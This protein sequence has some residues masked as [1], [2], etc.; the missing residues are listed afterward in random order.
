MTDP[1]PE[2]ADSDRSLDV[3]VLVDEIADEF[4]LAVR[5]GTIL[6]IDA[7][8]ASHPTVIANPAIEVPL[9]RMLETLRLL[10]G[11]GAESF[12]AGKPA[13][14]LPEQEFGLPEIAD[15]RLLRVAGRGGMGVVYEAMQLSLSRKVALKVLPEH[16]FGNPNALARFQLEARSAAGLHHT[17]IVPVFEV[18]NDGRHCFYAMQFIEGHSLDEVIR[19]LREIRD[20]DESKS[21][22]GLP[23]EVEPTV[24]EVA[25]TFGDEI[26]KPQLLASST[27][28]SS[29]TTSVSQQSKPFFRN[30]AR[31]GRQIAD[32]LG[33]A[34]QRG[35]VHRDIKPSNI[36]LDPQGVAWITD[37]GLAKTDDVDLTRDGDVVGTLRYMSPERFAGTCD[38]CSDVYSLGVT[39]YEM[40]ALQSPFAG[41][42]RLSLISAIQ[43]VGPPSLRSLNTR[44][45]R[46]LQ[47]IVEKAMEKEPRR[48]YRTAAAMADDLER[49]LDGRPIWARRVGA[50]ECLWLWSKNNASLASSIA[51]IALL[52]VCGAIGSTFAAFH[53]RAQERTQAQLAMEKMAESQRANRQRDAANQNAYF[54]DIR[55]SYQDWE[56]GDVR[57]MQTALRRYVPKQDEQPKQDEKDIRGWEWNYLLSLS[58]QSETTLTNFEGFFHQLQW[59][60]DGMRLFGCGSQGGLFIW[61][62]QGELIK[63]IE[64]PGIQRFALSHDGSEVATVRG[65]SDL[66]FWNTQT[67]ELVQTIRVAGGDA[68]LS[69]VGWGKFPNLITVGSA[70]TAKNP[71]GE[72]F[73]LE[74]FTQFILQHQDGNQTRANWMLARPQGDA[75]AVGGPKMGVTIVFAGCEMQT[76][77]D[78]QVLNSFNDL[79]CL[80]WHP[81][82]RRI[83]VGNVSIG[84]SLFE[85]NRGERLPKLLFRTSDLT[86]ADAVTFSPD[87]K[88]MIVGNRAGR[89]DVY[90]LESREKIVSYRGHMKNVLAVAAHPSGKLIAS[91]GDDGAIRFWT[92]NNDLV[93]MPANASLDQEGVSPDG[94]WRWVQQDH[95]VSVLDAQTGQ[96]MASLS[97]K[98]GPVQAK[99][100]P[101]VDRAVFFEEKQYGDDGQIVFDTRSWDLIGQAGAFS[102]T[103]PQIDSR[104]DFVVSS[105]KGVVS[106]FSGRTGDIKSFLVD[107]NVV[108]AK[109]GSIESAH[110]GVSLSPTGDRFVT[111]SGGEFKLWDTQ[112]C[113][114]LAHFYGHQSGELIQRV[115]WSNQR[116]LIATGGS[117]QT[118]II[119]DADQQTRL[120]TLRGLQ[121]APSKIIFGFNEDDSRFMS[122]DSQSLKV[123]DVTTGRELLSMPLNAE[124]KSVFENFTVIQTSAVILP[125]AHKSAVGDSAPFV[126]LAKVESLETNLPT[127]DEFSHQK[128]HGL[129]RDLVC[130]PQRKTHDPE[131]GLTISEQA[132]QKN[133]GDPDYL[134][135]HAL[136]QYRIGDIDAAQRSLQTAADLGLT[137]HVTAQSLAALCQLAK[138]QP[139][140]NL[141]LDLAKSVQTKT[142]AHNPAL[143]PIVRECADAIYHHRRSTAKIE[144]GSS[145]ARIVVNDLGDDFYL[146]D[147]DR[148]S[149]REALIAVADGGTI[150]FSVT[151]AIELRMGPIHINKSVT[152]VGPGWNELSLSGS[153]AHRLLIID[154][155]EAQN[156]ATVSISG[157]RLTAGFSDQPVHVQTNPS[158]ISV[159]ESL[160]LADCRVDNNHVITA[161]GNMLYAASD[162]VLEVVR[163]AFEQNSANEG[164]AIGAY[165]AL[166][167][168]IDSC[169]FIGNKRVDGNSG[170][171]NVILCSGSMKIVNSTFANNRSRDRGAVGGTKRGCNLQIQN[172][173]F[174]DNRGGGL[175]CNQQPA[176]PFSG[177]VNVTNCL[178]SGNIDVDGKPMDVRTISDFKAT[179]SHSIIGSGEGM[180]IDG[181]NNLTGVDPLLG[182]LADNGGPTKTRALLKNSPAINA[183]SNNDLPTDQRGQAIQG[184]R[185]IGAFEFQD[186]WF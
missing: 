69:T 161:S 153:D 63:K 135:V 154:D 66:R 37:F 109:S 140:E 92:P 169:S 48:R 19:Q 185:D 62:H 1:G 55:Q 72:F 60:A 88:Q 84:I 176:G 85:V 139:I 26:I 12:A 183:G 8:V 79:S 123:W 36:I 58:N 145:Q 78:V 56:N 101:K 111:A 126:A 131:R 97:P 2:D 130:D 163:C 100:F 179:I 70:P 133:P 181:G 110:V 177:Q 15:Y 134:L 146:P 30:V 91:S 132:I 180:Y 73:A 159:Y 138:N 120:Q 45:P 50:A 17:N 65:D 54:A 86:T 151:G 102:E 121:D 46:D 74:R 127:D 148:I 95:N 158:I 49:F 166:E 167:A 35:I 28:T 59:S 80:C 33:H 122:A 14:P 116:E 89:V 186:Q 124:S 117:D 142:S 152:I 136:A 4:L 67:C 21:R 103:K 76:Q 41:H 184:T 156:R 178:F 38:A 143:L 87:G 149:L 47:T 99:W 147:D 141:S 83:A 34:H 51:A 9:R 11:L 175:Y 164:T 90:D 119:W 82:G 27:T 24:A 42:D 77:I 61:D 113:K 20:N 94:R 75:I 7:F 6:D 129:A 137:D 81:D 29:A 98:E 32:G 96:L 104:G 182:P 168:S 172:C 43:E 171:A 16:S 105:V 44:V 39:L 128:M 114:E 150:E 173:T 5:S 118:I 3:D 31:I 160:S 64:M 108:K 40:L 165:G 106:L 25:K 23:E 155:G 93:P 144:T 107:A 53:F 68:V 174:T 157:M 170:D 71:A 57:R 125:P 162:S 22:H 112:A 13:E 52:L 10:H 18:G 115:C